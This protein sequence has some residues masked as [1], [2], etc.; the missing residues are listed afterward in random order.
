M[1][2]EASVTLMTLMFGMWAAAIWATFTHRE[3]RHSDW[4]I[5]EKGHRTAA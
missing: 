1:L 2:W 4:L 5:Q 3:G